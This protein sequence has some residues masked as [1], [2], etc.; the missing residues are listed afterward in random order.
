MRDAWLLVHVMMVLL[1]YAAL[2]LTAVASIFY[3]IQERQLKRKKPLD[4]PSIAQLSS[5]CRRS[6]RSTT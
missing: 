4:L 6:A 3:L 5:A 2:L 1:G